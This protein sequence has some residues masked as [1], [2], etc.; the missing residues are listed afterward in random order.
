MEKGYLLHLSHYDPVWCA[1]KATEEPFDLN[2]GVEIVDALAAEGFNLLFIGCSDGV[3]YQS[4][5]ELARP[6]SIPMRGLKRLVDHAVK[7]GLE[8]VPKLN[9]SKSERNKHDNWIRKSG[10]RWQEDFET[11]AYWQKAFEII[12]EVNETCLPKR[13]FHIGMDEDHD[14]SYTQ[15]VDAIGIL[16]AGLS[17]RGL[18]TIMWNDAA[19]AI[20]YAPALVHAE[21]VTSAL[22][23][24]S[25]DVIQIL[26]NY[27]SVPEAQINDIATKGFELWGAPGKDPVQAKG[28]RDA[29][30]KAK[31]KGLLMTT[32]AQC[33]PPNRELLL[34]GIHSLGA[35]Y[36]SEE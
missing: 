33:R 7:A 9:F 6:Y 17:K 16:R 15:Y 8:I 12:D 21:K 31:G 18:R 28:F 5:P 14:R 2:L 27:G 10:A 34:D 3:Q 25:R 32:W 23:R 4:H 19:C 26:W 35:I 13:F 20:N 36:R 24:I 30:S 1:R 11:P 29:L 22:D